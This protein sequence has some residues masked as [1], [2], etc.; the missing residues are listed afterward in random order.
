MPLPSATDGAVLAVRRKTNSEIGRS[1]V[2]TTCSVPV[3]VVRSGANVKCS[4][5]RGRCGSGAA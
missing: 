1:G 3:T 2:N 4:A 5:T